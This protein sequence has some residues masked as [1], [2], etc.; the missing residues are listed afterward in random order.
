MSSDSLFVTSDRSSATAETSGCAAAS[1]W[2]LLGG[3][4]ACAGAAS[5][6][7]AMVGGDVHLLRSR[8]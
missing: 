8:P 4:A 1:F 5:A 6:T 2:L 3:S 7:S